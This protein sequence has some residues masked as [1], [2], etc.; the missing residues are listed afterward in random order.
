MTRLPIF[1]FLVAAGAAHAQRHQL[2]MN[3][4]LSQRGVDI[5]EQQM[6]LRHDLSACHA[7]AFEET[8]TVEDEGKRKAL[9]V[10]MFNRCMD[11]KGWA[12]RDPGSRKPPAKAPK[13][14]SA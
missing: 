7:S 8:R 6:I 9:G 11:T 14:S 2:W 10:A 13:E 1:L 5:G 3:H 4:G 12:P